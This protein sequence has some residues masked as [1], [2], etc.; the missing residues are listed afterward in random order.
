[1]SRTLRVATLLFACAAL[2][3]ACLLDAGPFQAD[4]TGGA[5]GT[6]T[7]S[8]TGGTTTTS[9]TGGTG[10]TGNMGG[11][12]G[13]GGSTFVC[14]DGVINTGEECDD[15]NSADADGCSPACAI[16]P[17]WSCTD[18]PSV[19]VETCGDGVL[20]LATGEECE[21]GN[22]TPG[23]GCT[24]GCKIE[25]G[26]DC[27]N[28]PLPSACFAVC[29]DEIIVPSKEG[30]DDGDTDGT[31]GCNGACSQAVLGWECDPV[32]GGKDSCNP[33]CGDT[34][35]VTGEAC[36]DGN[37]DSG[38]GCSATC[39]LESTCPNG[40]VEPGEECDGD[41]PGLD[42]CDA[43]CKLLDPALAVCKDAP[44]IPQGSFNIGTGTFEVVHEG[45]NDPTK[46]GAPLLLSDVPPP[47]GCKDTYNAPVLH[48][49]V[50]GSRPS[51]LTLETLL[52]QPV[53]GQATFKNTQIWVY[54]DCPRK[55]DYEGCDN[56]GADAEK[57][58]KFTTGYIPAKTTLFIVVSGE[59]PGGGADNGYYALKITEQPVKL[60][61]HQDFGDETTP[62]LYNL[63]AGMTPMVTGDGDWRTCVGGVGILC[64][65]DEPSSHSRGAFGWAFSDA[66]T[67]TTAF[68]LT[69][70]F[71]LTGV[72]ARASYAYRV[73]NSV[74]IESGKAEPLADGSPTSGA[75]TYSPPAAGR[76]V[77]PLQSSQNAR[78]RF[79]YEDGSSASAGNFAVDDIHVYGW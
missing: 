23:D 73:T 12:G 75:I 34:L 14:G 68:L 48:R 63:P 25:D 35:V 66:D 55:A 36:D 28:D 52:T 78:V 71:D 69:P 42:E 41:G 18:E 37:P 13:T 67:Q 62:G 10:N 54:R 30:C 51:F 53:G 39:A 40:I 64:F 33:I 8:N 58:S 46:G 11:T 24:A 7:T 29:G 15:G 9:N 3:P 65:G 20:D 47:V 61:Y 59:G 56:D 4:A 76:S 5:G 70:I 27:D 17:G 19:C 77:I 72:T 32:T 45:A 16:E 31:S 60:F 57:L 38:D 74:A 79:T 22:L 43:N 21:D 26:W 50:T 6:G 2:A 1:M 49:Y 44:L